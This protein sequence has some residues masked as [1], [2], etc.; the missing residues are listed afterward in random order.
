M[1]LERLAN[2]AIDLFAT[3]CA[4]SRTQ[5]IIETS[6]DD[7]MLVARSLALCDVF[8]VQAGLRFR[9]NRIALESGAVD[10]QQRLIASH[11][12]EASGYPIPP[13]V[14]AAPPTPLPNARSAT[15]R[16]PSARR[17]KGN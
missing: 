11:I 8:C 2:M 15:K 16:T 7:E 14:I 4:M 12:R 1:I 5:R 6:A 17:S 10:D 13:A 9:A 3:A